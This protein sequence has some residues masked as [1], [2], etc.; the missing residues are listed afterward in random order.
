MDDTA[1]AEFVDSYVAGKCEWGPAELY[2]AAQPFDITWV[3]VSLVINHS[4]MAVTG[5][6]PNYQSGHHHELK[7]ICAGYI[8]LEQL[9]DPMILYAHGGLLN[10]HKIGQ[11][12]HFVPIHQPRTIELAFKFDE[13][14]IAQYANVRDIKQVSD[15]LHTSQISESAVEAIFALV[16]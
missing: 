7:N 15:L 9:K 14:T 1:T 2:W 3:L 11:R 10:Q 16:Q 5:V 4:C 6:L 13:C 12:T 8:A